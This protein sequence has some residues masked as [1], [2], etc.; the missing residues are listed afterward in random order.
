MPSGK[1]IDWSKYDDLIKKE[2]S[3]YTIIDFRK[4]FIPTVSDKAVGAR[5]RKLGIEPQSYK[6]TAEHKASIAKTVS[7]ESDTILKFIRENRDLMSNSEMAKQLNISMATLCRILAKHNIK[8]TAQGLQRARVQ[9]KEKQRGKVP[10][11]KGK[12][13]SLDFRIKCAK[14]RQRQSGRLSQIQLTFYNILDELGINYYRDSEAECRFG[15]WTFDARI[16]HDGFDFLVEV[17]GDYIHSLPKNTVKDEAKAT[18]MQRYFPN[19]PIKYVWEHEFGAANRV[20]FQVLSWLNK[21]QPKQQLFNLDEISIRPI[22]SNDAR[23]FVA[24]YHYLEKMS[25][26]ICIGA[27]W[28]DKLIAVSVWGAPTRRETADRLGVKLSECLELRRFVIHDSYH[29]RNFASWFL[30]RCE[31]MLPEST[32]VLVSFADL[33]MEHH[34]TIYKSTNWTE[35]G[36][37]TNSYFYVDK[38]GYVMLKKTLYNRASKMHMSEADFA[39]TYG[40]SKVRTPPKKRFIKICDTGKYQVR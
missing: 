38:D 34:G 17:Q 7:K 29:K 2:L 21:D 39:I 24:T 14:A 1:K 30:S 35:D 33:G 36:L 3:N 28:G 37:T 25:G 32:R 10:W 23:L 20:R 19:L 18:Y 13:M 16:I 11:N 27:F 9:I 5:A 6:P 40:Y 15:P 31:R 8:P 12:E 4:K 26:R 22:Q